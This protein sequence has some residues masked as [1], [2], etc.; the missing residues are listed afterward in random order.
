MRTEGKRWQAASPRRVKCRN[1]ADDSRAGRR[2]IESSRNSS[3][4]TMQTRRNAMRCGNIQCTHQT[5]RGSNGGQR[6]T[7]PNAKNENRKNTLARTGKRYASNAYAIQIEKHETRGRRT[8]RAH[9]NRSAKKWARGMNREK[10]P[11]TAD[12]TGHWRQSTRTLSITNNRK[13]RVPP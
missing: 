11:R 2:R 9:R 5:K 10:T 1:T 7:Q 6:P 8:L 13:T 3:H 4:N 12:G